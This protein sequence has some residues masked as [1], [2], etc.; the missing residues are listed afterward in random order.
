MKHTIRVNVCPDCRQRC[1]DEL[2]RRGKPNVGTKVDKDTS[3]VLLKLLCDA[4]LQSAGL[5][6]I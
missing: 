2:R 3:H 4:C 1:A 5:T 6:R